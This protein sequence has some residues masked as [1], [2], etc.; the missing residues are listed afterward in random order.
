[1]TQE[2]PAPAASFLFGAE[3]PFAIL[4]RLFPRSTVLGPTDFVPDASASALLRLLPAAAYMTDAEGRISFFNDAAAE[5][6]GRSPEVGVDRW[7][8]SWRLYNL[9]GTPLPTDQSPAA[10]TLRTGEPVRGIEAIAERPDG[11]RIRFL[12]YP[13]PFKNADGTVTGAINLLVDVTDLRKAETDSQLLANIVSSSD[14]AIVSKSLDGIITSWN[15]GAERIFGY[16]AAEMVGTS[17]TR[18]IP[19]ELHPEE[20]QVLARL[21]RGERIDHYET[22]RVARDG[23]RVD[24]SLTV[25][26]IRDRF[27]KVTG[28][29][30]VARD[31]TERKQS[32][33]SQLLLMGE[34]SHR[35]K[36]TLA[37]VQAI[38][39][40]SLR[41]SRD[42][43]EFVPAFTGRIHALARAH[44][45]LSETRWEG[46]EV[47][48]LVRDQVLLG[49]PDDRISVRGPGLTLEPQPALHLAMVLHELGT[50]ARKYGALSVPHGRLTIEWLV[51]GSSKGHTLELRWTEA[52]GPPVTAPARPGF[53]T[54]LI[55]ESLMAHDGGATIT[56]GVDGLTCV[57]KLPLA[58]QHRRLGV[59]AAPAVPFSPQGMADRVRLHGKRILVVEDEPLI[60]MEIEATLRDGGCLIVGPAGEPGEALRLLASGCDAALL[61]ANLGGEPVDELAAA[62][63]RAG[64]P[65]AFITGYGVDGVPA[66]FR[67][68]MIVSKPFGKEQL[69]ACLAKLMQDRTDPDVYQLGMAT[70]G[71]A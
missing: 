22:I 61:D 42:A 46:I 49:V 6:W 15:T 9:D 39:T 11:T 12:Q 51:A 2:R 63:T 67:D 5:L 29:S 25:S 18:I 27:G 13:T 3:R 69:L 66:A 71:K 26:P 38:A 45:L 28:A 36:N 43:A 58:E 7:C 8:G 44:D 20:W 16:S 52:G 59:L 40:Q 23:R 41:R 47:G 14:D 64:I 31:V 65:F 54:R 57:L 19:P 33:K 30:K 60:A 35:V 37:T 70:A 4:A 17:I 56:Y 48:S 68:R 32:E 55:E 10:I 50:N 34:L 53:G 62:L 1:M 21:R 24:I